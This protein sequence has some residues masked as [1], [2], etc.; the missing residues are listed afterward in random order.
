M[1]ANASIAATNNGAQQTILSSS[2]Q[3]PDPCAVRAFEWFA[4]TSTGGRWTNRGLLNITPRPSNT[5]W[6]SWWRQTVTTRRE[7]ETNSIP[8][9]EVGTASVDDDGLPAIIAFNEDFSGSHSNPKRETCPHGYLLRNHMVFK[10]GLTTFLPSPPHAWSAVCFLH[11]KSF[12]YSS[13]IHT[14]YCHTVPTEMIMCHVYKLY[15]GVD[16]R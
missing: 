5:E 8:S 9:N 7:F 14:Y 6:L 4:H 15:D 1:N 12:T 3:M 10:T 2:L 13:S 11:R 16:S